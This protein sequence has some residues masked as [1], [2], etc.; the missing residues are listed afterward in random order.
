MMPIRKRAWS[1]ESVMI[2]HSTKRDLTDALD[3][4]CSL[5]LPDIDQQT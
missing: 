5:E 4:D 2:I 3:I 1:G